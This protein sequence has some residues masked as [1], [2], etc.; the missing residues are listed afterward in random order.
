MDVIPEVN[1]FGTTLKPV[2]LPQVSHN[3]SLNKTK[4]EL[5]NILNDR[6]TFVHKYFDELDKMRSKQIKKIEELGKF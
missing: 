1:N 3:N 5:N 2:S 6:K 4:S